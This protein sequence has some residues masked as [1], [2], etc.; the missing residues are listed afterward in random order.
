MRW[1]AEV[2]R[3]RVPVAAPATGSGPHGSR[4]TARP[5]AW[6]VRWRASDTRFGLTDGEAA[7]AADGDAGAVEDQRAL[8][9]T[10]RH[11]RDQSLIGCSSTV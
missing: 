11:R 3:L 6:P 4:G 10:A 5:G 2:S 7:P 9:I 8:G 1:R